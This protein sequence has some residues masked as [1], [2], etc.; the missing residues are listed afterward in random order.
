MAKQESIDWLLEIYEEQHAH[1]FRLATLLGAGPKAGEIV[2]DAMLALLRRR[3]RVVDPVERVELLREQVIHLTH[4]VGF[5]ANLPVPEDGRY[6]ALMRTVYDLPQQLGEIVVVAHYLNVFGPELSHVMRTTLRG[7]NRRLEVALNMLR[8]RLGGSGDLE[9]LSQELTAALKS[10]GK[11][12]KAIP[13]EGIEEELRKRRRLTVGKVRAQLVFVACLV[14]MSLGAIGA[15]A[16]RDTTDAITTSEAPDTR[17]LPSGGAQAAV[18]A[19]VRGMPIYY[20]GRTNNL[21]YREQRNLPSTASLPRAAV[22]ALFTLVPNDPD[23]TSLWEGTVNDVRFLDATA[24]VDLSAETYAN[25]I[26]SSEHSEAAINQLVATLA[27][28]MKEPQMRVRFLADGQPAPGVFGADEGFRVPGM[29]QR[30][31]LWIT[32]PRN[33][34][35]VGTD[36]LR[37]TGTTKPAYG[38]PVITI[39]NLETKQKIVNVVAQT[40]LSANP[41]GWLEWS[42]SVNLWEPGSYEVTA[43][44]TPEKPGGDNA[45]V[46]ENKVIRVS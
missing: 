33:G 38:A 43:V 39:T 15:A 37:I 25:L 28:T 14:A 45:Q 40:A 18:R 5:R 12:I 41:E 36:V 27:E 16:T 21:L 9:A 32:N 42:V 7:A 20:V 3:N 2:R 26:K 4:P 10:L 6:L 29:A 8:H 1:L 24:T 44:G 31:G 13:D 11:Q 22:E 19:V 34:D 46:S 23:Y 35:T 30:P 17:P